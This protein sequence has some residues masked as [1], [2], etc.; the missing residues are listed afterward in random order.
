MEDSVMFKRKCPECGHDMDGPAK[1]SELTM[2]HGKIIKRYYIM[3]SCPNCMELIIRP[4]M[5][6]KPWRIA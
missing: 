5:K 2:I 1:D 4:V 6:E 3:W